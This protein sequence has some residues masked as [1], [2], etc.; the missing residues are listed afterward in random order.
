MTGAKLVILQKLGS[1]YLDRVHD[2]VKSV[3]TWKRVLQ[4]QPGHPKALRVLRDSHL[5][6]GDYDGLT[7]LYAQ[8]QDWDGL[9]EVLVSGSR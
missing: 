3:A 1:L 2:T 4:V 9:A 7:E 5:A 8:T 6:N